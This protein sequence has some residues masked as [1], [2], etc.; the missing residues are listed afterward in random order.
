MW[1]IIEILFLAAIVLISITE[2]FLPIIFNKPLFGS[3]RKSTKVNS[4]EEK[5]SDPS[6]PLVEKI[7]K[8]KEKVEEVVEEVKEVQNEVA[9]NYKSAKELKKES[10]NL[11][12]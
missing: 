5:K 1:P 9:E 4:S 2:F 11:L 12:K 6:S 7:T 8:A 10:D 3:F